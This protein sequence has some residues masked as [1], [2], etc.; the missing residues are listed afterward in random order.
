MGRQRRGSNTVYRSP[1]SWPG[2]VTWVAQDLGDPAITSRSKTG[3]VY[4]WN[5]V[6]DWKDSPVVVDKYT[7]DSTKRLWDG[8]NA[9]DLGEGLIGS[10]LD[11]PGTVSALVAIALAFFIIYWIIAGPGLYAYLANKCQPT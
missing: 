5:K 6:F 4:V 2:A 3:W 7:T 9:V 10:Q 11:L 8:G 1:G